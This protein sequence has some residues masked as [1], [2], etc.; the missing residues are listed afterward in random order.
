MEKKR[1]L[2]GFVVWHV[3]CAVIMTS[4]VALGGQADSQSEPADR[5]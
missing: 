3:L 4:S 5:L 2:S 1:R